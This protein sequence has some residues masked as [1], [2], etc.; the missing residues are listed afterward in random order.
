VHRQ[1]ARDCRFDAF[2]FRLLDDDARGGQ[3]ICC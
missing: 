3:T 2:A 1:T